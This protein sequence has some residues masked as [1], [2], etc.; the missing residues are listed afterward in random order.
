MCCGNVCS[1]KLTNENEMLYSCF[2]FLLGGE[3]ECAVAAVREVGVRQ[4]RR[5]AQCVHRAGIPQPLR[6][7]QMFA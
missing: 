5:F 3:R 4:E 6:R 7:H 1:V 2:V